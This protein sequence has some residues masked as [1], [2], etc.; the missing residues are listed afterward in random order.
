MRDR[1]ILRQL[2]QRRVS[3]VWGRTGGKKD[4]SN[5]SVTPHKNNSQEQDEKKKKRK[6]Q[7]VVGISY[8][9]MYSIAGGI[10]THHMLYTAPLVLGTVLSQ[11]AI[12]V[13]LYLRVVVY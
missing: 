6:Q 8:T 5:P 10:S 2:A 1:D 3:A 9:Y 7:S 12:K 11:T 13:G 4:N